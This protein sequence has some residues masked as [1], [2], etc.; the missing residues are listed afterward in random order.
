MP[1]KRWTISVVARCWEADMPL[2]KTWTTADGKDC[3]IRQ[4]STR[5]IKACIEYTFLRG[6]GWRDRH[7]V[8]LEKELRR[9]QRLKWDVFIMIKTG[10]HNAA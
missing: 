5:H 6:L 9:R 8:A 7:L 1:S 4:M 10:E 2:P 3:Q